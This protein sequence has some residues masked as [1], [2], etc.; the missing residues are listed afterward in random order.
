[1]ILEALADYLR[2][3]IEAEV[4]YVKRSR[5]DIV[6]IGIRPMHNRNTLMEILII[7][8]NF[9]VQADRHLNTPRVRKFSIHDPTSLPNLELFVNQQLQQ[10]YEDFVKSRLEFVGIFSLSLITIVLT[11]FIVWRIFG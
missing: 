8:E 1:M 4:R 9:V 6:Y 11:M 2:N 5:T 3:E 10:Y 7:D